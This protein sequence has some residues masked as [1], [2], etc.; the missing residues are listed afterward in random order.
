MIQKYNSDF[1]SSILNRLLLL[2]VTGLLA[3]SAAFAQTASISP[4][5]AALTEANLNT[6]SLGIVLGGETF[7][8]ATLPV[9]SFSLVGAPTGTSIASVTWT[10]TTTATIVLGF[11]YTDFETDQSM[12][13][14][15]RAGELTVTSSGVLTSSSVPVE[16]LQEAATINNPGLNEHTLNTQTVTVTLV[17]ETFINPGTMG[18]GNFTLNGAPGGLT[19]FG[20]VGTPTSTQAVLDLAF[21]PGDFDA[22]FTNFSVTINQ[23]VL[24]QSNTDL[25]TT[26]AITIAHVV[27]S[28]TLTSDQPL[29]EANLDLRILT[30]TLVNDQFVVPG[31]VDENYFYLIN[32]PAGLTISSA[33]ATAP[34]L[35]TIQLTFDGTDFDTDIT[36][37]AVGV[38]PSGLVYT[39]DDDLIT[40]PLTITA[41]AENPVAT[42]T[43]PAL[44]EYNLNG[45]TISINLTDETFITPGT[46][47][48]GNFTPVNAPPGLSIQSINTPTSTSVNLVLLFDLTDFDINYDDFQILIDDIVLVQSTEDLA[49]NSLP[50][51]Y[52]L[53]P[54][55]TNVS[56]PNDTMRIGSVVEVTITVEDDEGN[57]FSLVP[58]GVIGGYPLENLGRIDATT[59]T[60]EFTVFEGGLNYAA[61]ADIHVNDVR[62]MNGTIPG[63]LY[64][65]Q[66]ISQDSDLLDANAPIIQY[67]YA[68]T[69][70]PQNVGSVIFLWIQATENGLGFDPISTVNAIPI[71]SPSIEIT[72]SGGGRY[73]LRYVVAEGDNHVNPGEIEVNMIAL[74]VAGNDS[75]P[76]SID[77]N[78]LSIDASTPVITNA[79]VSSNDDDIIVGETIDIVVD[80]DQA[81]Y[82]NHDESTWINGVYVD[83]PATDP[84][85]LTFTDLGNGSYQYSYTVQ[86]EDGAVTRG[87]LAIYIV[88]Q[89]AAPFSNVSLAFTDLNP[90]N[91][92]ITTNRPSASISGPSEICHG[93]SALLTVIL[94][95]T[96]PWTMDISDGTSTV[97]HTSA[98]S[99]YSFWVY[100]EVTTNYT[101]ER[102]VDGTGLDNTGSGNVSLTVH[103]LPVVQITNLQGLYDVS[104]EAVLLEYTPPGGTFTGPGISESPW[105]FDP[106]DAGV[107][108]ENSPH[109]I[110]YSYRDELTGCTNSDIR[111]VTVVSGSGFI[112]FEKDVACFNDSTFLITGFNI[113]GTTGSFSVQPNQ[114]GAFEDLGNDTAILRP[115]VYD[116]NANQDLTIVYTF[117]DQ[118]GL[119][120]PLPRSLTIEYLED[121]NIFEPPSLEFC[122]NVDPIA[123]NG[124][125]DVGYT[126][127]SLNQGVVVDSSGNYYFDPEIADTGTILVIYEYISPNQCQVSDS[128]ELIVNDAPD[129][130]F[131]VAEPCIPLDGGVVQFESRSDTGSVRWLWGFGDPESGL[132]NNRSVDEDPFHHYEDTG[133]YTVSLSVSNDDCDDQAVKTIEISPSPIADFAWNSNCKTD[134]AII[135]TGKETVYR[136]DTVSNWSWKVD[137]SGS[138]IFR[139]DTSGGQFSYAFPSEGMYSI[140]YKVITSSGCADSINKPLSLSPTHILSPINLYT[141]DFELDGHG[142]EASALP[143]SQNSWTYDPVSPDEFPI[144]AASGT[145]AWYTDRP[146]Q[147]TPENSWVLSPCFS[148]AD[149]FYRPMVS[150]EIKR[151]L[152]RNLDGA[153]L[154]Y[155][156]DNEITW[157]NI[158]NADDGGLIWYNSKIIV[159]DVGGQSA[160]WTG[161]LVPGEDTEWYKA[162]HDLDKLVGEPEVRFRVAFGAWDHARTETN[163][164]LLSTISPS[165]SAPGCLC[166]NTSAM[167]IHPNVLKLT[168]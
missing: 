134:A 76:E 39:S 70:G 145:R 15:I 69:N 84:P 40:G 31:S 97:Q 157:N 113:Y 6:A 83:P 80:A 68:S 124:N 167:P 166:W 48:P 18:I 112:T 50:I 53:E 30:V 99:P 108:G 162:A 110:V 37:F 121:A 24:R 74:D 79:Y 133:S 118:S 127:T 36:D 152:D 146:D 66:Y 43:G 106:E 163:D 132:N 23:S 1:H 107:S 41:T 117:E 60:C 29:T 8:D 56:I 87:D 72:E 131:I 25:T 159:P 90:N 156:T 55:I 73:R 111:E 89:D 20:F 46:L 142:W 143:Q 136:P 154:Q 32:A 141:E 5:P 165:V 57:M 158:G 47:V 85:H 27:E 54:V 3:S 168:Q 128:V 51:T 71:S 21:T 138:E 96:A 19:L 137:S 150:L 61:S 95:G 155:T 45:N 119:P 88:L 13:I 140:S 16:A 101:V 130:G 67:I 122:Q 11:N 86:E 102:V 139:T 164:G 58:G 94:G 78:T 91:V 2:V 129:A 92:Q 98:T 153:V 123:L 4:T 105:T 151:S 81:G 82:R 125:Y 44:T 12:S 120:I 104:S 49:T 161:E 14:N 135:M 126:F 59:Y 22:D 52:G 33:Y 75:D 64:T 9:D 109:E 115:N 160:G 103:E 28:A 149:T 114:P 148:F 17:E 62:L 116:L 63:N 100:P 77:L 93:D 42:L 34:T 35:A 26:P 10:S 147:A 65:L 7:I 144:D 38:Y